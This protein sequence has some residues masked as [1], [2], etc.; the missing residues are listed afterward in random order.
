M[1]NI[2][3]FKV[4]I[5]NK[6]ENEFPIDLENVD[7]LVKFCLKEI[8]LEN[9]PSNVSEVSIVF[10]D[11]LEIQKLNLTYRSKDYPTDVLSFS[12]IEGSNS[13]NATSLGDIIISLETAK[14]QAPEFENDFNSEIK[15]LLVHGLLHLLGYDHENVSIEQANKMFELEKFLFDKL[16]TTRLLLI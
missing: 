1:Q 15:R 13:V 7:L 12:Q 4:Y 10:T 11:D 3:L 2:E 9:L 8:S 5:I 16:N 14:K 6:L